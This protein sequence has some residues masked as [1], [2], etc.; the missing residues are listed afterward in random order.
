MTNPDR[1]SDCQHAQHPNRYFLQYKQKVVLVHCIKA[2]RRSRGI[3]PLFLNLG[4][5]WKLVFNFT[6]QPLCPQ[7]K[8]RYSLNRRASVPQSRSG[9]FGQ[10][11]SF[12]PLPEFEPVWLSLHIGLILKQVSGLIIRINGKMWKE[13]SYFMLLSYVPSYVLPLSFRL[14]LCIVNPFCKSQTCG[15]KVKYIVCPTFP[16]LGLT[17]TLQICR[18]KLV[19]C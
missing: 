5:V 6:P 19:S 12:L 13:L 3:S 17:L 2:Y 18:L 8:S 4:T 15:Q 10:E 14:L 7:E 16:T 1:S 11:R 9:H